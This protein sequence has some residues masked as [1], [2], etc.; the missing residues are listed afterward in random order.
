M[1]YESSDGDC[2]RYESYQDRVYFGIILAMCTCTCIVAQ[3]ELSVGNLNWSF[4]EEAG[5]K[6]SADAGQSASSVKTKE[7]R[8][9][10]NRAKELV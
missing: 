8:C 10:G 4:A 2:L 5:C 3:G 6:R 9:Q 7:K 1:R